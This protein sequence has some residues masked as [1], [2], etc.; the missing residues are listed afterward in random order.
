VYPEQ[1]TLNLGKESPIPP[2]LLGHN[3]G[4]IVHDQQATWL[5]TWKENINDTSKYV[6]LAPNSSWKGQSDMKKFDKA[7]ELKVRQCTATGDDD[8]RMRA[9][10]S[11]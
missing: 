8:D 2:T 7:R 11:L 1:V 6:F 9:T 5:A 3:W 4:K 10:Q